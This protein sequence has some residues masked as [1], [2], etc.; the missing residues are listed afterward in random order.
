MPRQ[1]VAQDSGEAVKWYRKAA[2]HGNADAGNTLGAIYAEG[3][4][5]PRDYVR[6]YAWFSMAMMAGDQ[7]AQ[8]NRDIAAGNMTPAQ[9]SEAEQLVLKAKPGK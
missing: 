2:S 8:A 7:R 5:V 6:A 9:I 4:G 3:R 1:G